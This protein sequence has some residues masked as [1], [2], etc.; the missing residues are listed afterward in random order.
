MRFETG[1]AGELVAVFDHPMPVVSQCVGYGFN[2]LV[3]LEKESDISIVDYWGILKFFSFVWGQL[4]MCIDPCLLISTFPCNNRLIYL[5]DT[6][7]F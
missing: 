6:L 5:R 3:G 7:V 2:L 4:H 1:K